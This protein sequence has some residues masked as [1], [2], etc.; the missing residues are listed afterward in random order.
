ML[1][2]SFDVDCK[3]PI[4]DIIVV[5]FWK[6]NV[7]LSDSEDQ[8]QTAPSVQSDID[9]RCLQKVGDSRIAAFGLCLMPQ[10]QITDCRRT[11]VRGPHGNR[12]E[13]VQFERW[14]FSFDTPSGAFLWFSRTIIIG[15]LSD[16]FWAIGKLVNSSSRR[17]LQKLDGAWM[18]FM[19]TFISKLFG[20]RTV[21]IRRLACLRPGV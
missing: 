15:R 2:K 8:D 4:N 1:S 18:I 3:N 14:Q 13:A 6:E 17:F 21:S 12:P 20:D 19:K 7:S 16:D 10:S 5:I 11:F 9:R